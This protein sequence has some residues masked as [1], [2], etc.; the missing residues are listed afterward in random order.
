MA[1]LSR[2]LKWLIDFFTGMSEDETRRV[3]GET[4]LSNAAFWNCV[5]KITG[6][7]GVMPLVLYRR[8]ANGKEMAT[9]DTRYRLTMRQ[10]NE[11]QTPVMFKQTLTGHAIMWGNA[12]AYIARSGRQ[13]RELIPLLP[14][15]TK[16]LMIKGKKFHITW[17][18]DAD[19]LLEFEQTGQVGPYHDVVM[20]ADED[21]VHIP[22][23]GMDGV[24]GISL[25]TVAARSIDAGIQGDKRYATQVK[26]GFASKGFVVVPPTMLRE[27]SE[28]KK[29]LEQFNAANSGSD[30]EGKVGMLREGMKYEAVAM[31]NQN[32]EFL[33]NRQFQRQDTAL[34]FLIE[35]ILGDGSSEVYKSF[36]E[37][38]AAYLKNCL[39]TWMTKW[40][41]ELNSKLL[42]PREKAADS[43]FFKFD[44]SVFLTTD[45]AASVSAY[46][47]AVEAMILTRNEARDALDYNT[48]EGGDVFENP[49]TTSGNNADA[50]DNSPDAQNLERSA[51]TAQISHLIGV[52]KNRILQFTDK[53]EK[54]LNQLDKFYGKFADTLQSAIDNYAAKPELAK[55]WCSESKAALLQV[56]DVATNE[57]LR[58]CVEEELSR[59]SQRVETLVTEICD[60]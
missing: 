39:L 38:Q 23:F 2:P 19:R 5:N 4:A 57:T 41:E 20:M 24:E 60:A 17:P 46:R 21:V 40:E 32:A 37:K 44:S 12:R 53:P 14:D 43:M 22:G 30:K 16:T 58:A 45:F 1:T 15:R 34:W 18:N 33:K 48:V 54:F 50:S 52:E 35:S 36:A 47:E 13:V 28:A 51:V 29:F 56:T 49:N 26:K 10:P 25:L 6:N 31:S 59:W 11:Y 8:T 42:L 27:E 7:I 55:K 3:S 9:D